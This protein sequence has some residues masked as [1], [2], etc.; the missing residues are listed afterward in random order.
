METLLQGLPMSS[1]NHH[2]STSLYLK[3]SLNVTNL[4]EGVSE[5]EVHIHL[6]Q[7]I[8]HSTHSVLVL[9][10]MGQ[11]QLWLALALRHLC[12]DLT[13]KKTS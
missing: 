1:N 3:I 2:D 13:A 4:R 7:A 12:L 8:K 11:P 6:K 5:Q 9:L 10:N